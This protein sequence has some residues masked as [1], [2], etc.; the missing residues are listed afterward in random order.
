MFMKTSVSGQLRLCLI[1][2]FFLSGVTPEPSV[3]PPVF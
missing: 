3:E 2:S 1:L